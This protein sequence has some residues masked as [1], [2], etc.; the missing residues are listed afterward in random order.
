MWRKLSPDGKEGL[1]KF[2]PMPLCRFM[3]AKM[4]WEEAQAEYKKPKRD[5]ER[6]KSLLF[7]EKGSSGKR[8]NLGAFNHALNVFI[9][10]PEST[11]AADAG[12][13]S[14]KIRE[15][16]EQNYGAKIK[17]TI[18]QDQL[19]KVRQMQFRSPAEKMAEDRTEEAIA[20]YLEVLG[21]YP[22]VKAQLDAVTRSHSHIC[23]FR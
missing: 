2:S 12:E 4:L 23:Y 20:E 5:D 7:G 14:E 17:T 13:M 11:W 21:R 6:V 19:A 22:E 10:Y 18:T 15:F 9:L 8:N 16:A 3:L 1:R